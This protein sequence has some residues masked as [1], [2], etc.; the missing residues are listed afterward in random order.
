MK[1]D[2]FTAPRVSNFKCAAGKKQTIFWDGETRGL[3]LRVTSAGAKSYVFET[4]LNG[5]TLRITI[6]DVQT[7]TV[8]AAQRIA[9]EYKAQTDKGINPRQVVADGLA[10]KQAARDAK[11]AADA[12]AQT[13]AQR[14]GLTLGEVWPLYINA[15]KSKWSAG[16]LQN[17][18]TLTAI[19][20]EPKKRGIGLTVAGPMAPLMPLALA[21]LTGARIA[22]WI[23]QEAAVRPTNTAQSYRL[24]R[25]FIRWAA[26]IPAYSGII[27]AE[28]YSA[29]KVREAV[30]KSQAADGDGLQREQLPTWFD[31]VHKIG[32]PVI[33]GYLQCLLLTGAR[34]E[35]LA[36]LQWS[37]VDF[38]WRSMTIKDKVE[39]TRT[40]P[41]T[42]FVASLMSALPRRNQFVFSSPKAASGYIEEPRIAHTKA[43]AAAG[44]PHVSLHGLRRSFGTLCEW[45]EMPSGISAQIMGHK[46]SA[47]AE[48]HYRRR[49]IDL[50]RKW[51]DQIEAW[52]LEQAGVS[53]V[54]LE[55][56]L[57]A[58]K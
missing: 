5:K 7:Y 18:L 55:P 32:N 12:A 42:P 14:R 51:H 33:A 22:A 36:A 47:L 23:E 57:R 52:I 24:L 15:R 58:V 8:K 35:E 50:L 37:D 4:R 20:G 26:D 39:G 56:G 25:A 49:P 3:G 13:E 38:Q 19:G 16:H 28:A 43:L 17:H 53:F 45:V 9:T 10:E 44:L 40:I 21:D 29:S 41:L 30:P 27:A 46:P 34:R 11:A 6:G 54:P 2:S 1:W 31:A 48:K